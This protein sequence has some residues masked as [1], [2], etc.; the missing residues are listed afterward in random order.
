MSLDV[1]LRFFGKKNF[2][3]TTIFPFFWD[4]QCCFTVILVETK[5]LCMQN[6]DFVVMKIQGLE[7]RNNENEAVEC[8]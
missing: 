8:R 2:M 3:F 1:K 4:L 5:D 7:W 6:Q